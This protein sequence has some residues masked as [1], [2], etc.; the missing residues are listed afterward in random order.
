MMRS[1]EGLD[2]GPFDLLIIGGGIYGAWTA[3]DA[4]LRGLKVAI[5]DKGDWASGTSSAS[6]KLIHGGLRYIEQL[7]F[8]L[9]K[10]S[11]NERRILAGIA[12]HRISPLRF[13]IPLYKGGPAGPL[14]MKIGLKL[15][16]LLAGKT[17]T[18]APYKSF[19]NQ[20]MLSLYPFLKKENLL[21]GLTYSDCMIDDARFTLEIIEGANRAGAVTLNYVRADNLLFSGERVCGASVTD[22]TN[23]ETKDIH[24]SLVINTA[25]PWLETFMRNASPGLTRL[26]KG[27]HLIM[28]PLDTSDALF[29]MTKKDKRIFFM[30]PWYGKTLI[31]TTDTDFKGTPDSVRV[32]SEDINY[33][34]TEA[35]HVLQNQSWNVS[36]VLGCFAGLRTLKNKS[37]SPPSSISREWSIDK[38]QAGLLTSIGGKFTSARADAVQLVDLAMKALKLPKYGNS[39]TKTLPLPW[40]PGDNYIK[41]NSDTLQAGVKA[42]LDPETSK[43]ALTRYGTAAKKIHEL[44]SEDPGLAE[45]LHPELPF[46]KAELVIGARDEMAVHLEDLLRRRL[47]VLILSVI[48]R[49]ILE[50]AAAIAA[51]LLGWTPEF[52][53]NEINSL[54]EKWGNACTPL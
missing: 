10:K 50:T 44:I 42:G 18:F 4:A 3:Y 9:V 2:K 47:P 17:E 28:P 33:L 22:L 26:V 39:P 24:A 54:M 20:E 19:S 35:R 13:A 46:S 12:P 41:W 25:G 52:C 5:I 23:N 15:Y 53:E 43:Y 32:T 11:L 16:D 1:P 14:K 48:N 34:L 37:G 7:R 29:I 27:I 38:S 40:S 21:A 36:S 31:G 6:S 51:P 45:R 8:G 30:I 49:D